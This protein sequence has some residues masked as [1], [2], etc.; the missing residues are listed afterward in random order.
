MTRRR[1]ASRSVTNQNAG[2]VVADERIVGVETGQQLDDFGVGLAQ[3]QVKYLVFAARALGNGDDQIPAV[4]GDLMVKAPVLVI[5]SLVNQRVVGL[6]RSQ[7]VEKNL[8]VV[9]GAG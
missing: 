5:A 1:G 9:I 4:V 3:V 8:L 2:A 7:L 6:R